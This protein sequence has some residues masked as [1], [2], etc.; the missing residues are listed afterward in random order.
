MVRNYAILNRYKIKKFRPLRYSK[1]KDDIVVILGSIAKF[2]TKESPKKDVWVG[3]NGLYWV[4]TM[5]KKGGYW[6]Y[7]SIGTPIDIVGVS[8]TIS[9]A[10]GLGKAVYY[11]PSGKMKQIGPAVRADFEMNG[12]N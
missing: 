6:V 5:K 10:R 12:S 11:A 3:T 7:G 1:S 2:K 4:Q 8:K 9:K